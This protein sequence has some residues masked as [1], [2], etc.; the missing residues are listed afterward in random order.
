MY[1]T[2]YLLKMRQLINYVQH[3]LS[4]ADEA[5][6]KLCTTHAIYWRWGNSFC[7][8]NRLYEKFFRKATEAN[9]ETYKKY[10]NRLNTTLRLAKQ[11]Y[12]SNV[13]EKEIN[14]LRI[15]WKILNS[16][17]RPNNHKK[18]SEKFVSGSET[19]TCPNEIALSLTNTLPI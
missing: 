1:N 14:N 4:T 7:R 13:L 17:I 6:D 8:N 16:I 12:F 5:I 3:M 9:K 2:C 15:A 10:R 19:Y 11:N 18:C